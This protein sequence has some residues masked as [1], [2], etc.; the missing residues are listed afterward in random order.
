MSLQPWIAGSIHHLKYFLNRFW[1]SS[2]LESNLFQLPPIMPA[3]EGE[4]AFCFYNDS[5]GLLFLLVILGI[6][7]FFTY[8]FM[9][10]RIY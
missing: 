1:I 3:E 8:A 2:K 7:N 4:N 6:L 10:L 9:Q 5:D